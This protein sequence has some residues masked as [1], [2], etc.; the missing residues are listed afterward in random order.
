MNLIYKQKQY[1]YA[2]VFTFLG[3][4]LC[5][6][7]WSSYQDKQEFKQKYTRAFAQVI[8]VRADAALGSRYPVIGFITYEDSIKV[9]HHA[10]D[11]SAS[12]Y[13]VGEVLD[14]YY[15]EINP[16]D[17][18]V[19]GNQWFGVTFLGLVGSVFLLVGLLMFYN[20]WEKQKLETW[21]KEKGDCLEAIFQSIGENKDLVLKNKI[22]CVLF[23]QWQGSIAEIPPLTFKSNTFFVDEVPQIPPSTKIKVYVDSK[24]QDKYFVDISFLED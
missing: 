12:S 10:K 23:C 18:H 15:D 5:F 9:Y 1:V 3:I 6:W 4:L 20:E 11:L 7:S 24:N 21:L 8:E 14:I 19:L 16:T 17:A 2:A 13:P 22:A